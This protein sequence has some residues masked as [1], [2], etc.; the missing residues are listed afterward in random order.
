MRWI[1]ELISPV[2]KNN[3]AAETD[4]RL[5]TKVSD[6]AAWITAL[7]NFSFETLRV[8]SEST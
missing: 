1:L 2:Q 6:Q 7:P 4:I 3:E 8:R 5:N